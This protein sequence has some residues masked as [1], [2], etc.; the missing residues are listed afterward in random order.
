MSTATGLSI[1]GAQ[2][3]KKFSTTIGNGVATSFTVTH[4]LATQD[5]TVTCKELPSQTALLVD[6][7]AIAPEKRALYSYHIG[8]GITYEMAFSFGYIRSATYGSMQFIGVAKEAGVAGSAVKV[9]PFGAVFTTTGLTAGAKYYLQLTPDL[10]T[11]NPL[12]NSVFS[13]ALTT[14]QMLIKKGY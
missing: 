5:V 7:L 6:W 3:P 9:I 13:Q 11:A 1:D 4:N 10:D 12:S 14:T 2:F 8:G